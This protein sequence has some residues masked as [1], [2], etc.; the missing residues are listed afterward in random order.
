MALIDSMWAQPK[1]Q[2]SS[3]QCR[4]GER[5]AKR[6]SPA[7][8]AVAVT[9]SSRLATGVETLRRVA[10]SSEQGGGKTVSRQGKKQKE[11]R[12]PSKEALTW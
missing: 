3:P 11:K 7:T 4:S 9:V 2:S 1:Q 10:Q 8:G 6:A 12:H 5:F